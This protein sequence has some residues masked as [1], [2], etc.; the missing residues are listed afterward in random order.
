MDRDVIKDEL[1]IL[2]DAYYEELEQYASHQQQFLVSR[3]KIA[4]PPG[5]GPFPG[6]VARYQRSARRSSPPRRAPQQRPDER[7]WEAGV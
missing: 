2:Y 4:P 5:L 1:E 7:E 3:G 6:S